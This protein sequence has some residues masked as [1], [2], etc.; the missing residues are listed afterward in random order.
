MTGIDD[1]HAEAV[2]TKVSLSLAGFEYRI[3]VGFDAGDLFSS[4]LLLSS[5]ELSD[6]TIYEPCI[7]T[8]LGTA[9][10]FC[11]AFLLKL[12]TVPL[13][14][15]FEYRIYVGFDAGDLFYDDTDRHTELQVLTACVW[16]SP[17]SPPTLIYV[18]P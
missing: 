5:L 16:S 8:L 13:G 15:G 4:F 14:A 18:V 6:K 3:Y 10:H 12:R 17:S 9:P 7:R 1:R 2:L 11:H